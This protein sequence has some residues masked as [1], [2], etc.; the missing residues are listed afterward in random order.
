[1][2]CLFLSL[3]YKPLNYSV[4]LTAL[5]KTLLM[6]TRDPSVHSFGPGCGD[7]LRMSFSLAT[8]SSSSW[9]ISRRSPGQQIDII[10][11]GSALGSLSCWPSL[12][13]FHRKASM[14]HPD[15][16]PK[17]P[18]L[19]PLNGVD[20]KRYSESLQDVRASL[21]VSQ[22]QPRHNRKL[23]SITLYPQTYF[24][25]H[26]QELMTIGW[27]TYRLVNSELCLK[28]LLSFHHDSLPWYND[29]FTAATTAIRLSISCPI[30]PTLVKKTLRNLS[31]RHYALNCK[32]PS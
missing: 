5:I 19:A 3:N 28:A 22:G 17:P 7:R 13:H 9:G 27:S 29:H 30:L 14:T 26:Y 31:T 2:H 18:Q 24:F 21:P 1:M 4:K 20:Q 15:Q 6:Q 8:S 12:E 32:R 16:M 10:P 11:P 25:S 23:I